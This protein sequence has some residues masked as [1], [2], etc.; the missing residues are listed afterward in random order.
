MSLSP[1]F[2]SLL[3]ILN[4][5][6]GKEKCKGPLTFQNDLQMLQRQIKWEFYLENCRNVLA[7]LPASSLSLAPSTSTVHLPKAHSSHSTAPL[8]NCKEFPTANK[9]KFELFRITSISLTTWSQPVFPTP[10]WLSFPLPLGRTRPCT[11]HLRPLSM[12]RTPLPFPSCVP[13][14]G[15][16]LP[17]TSISRNP[18]PLSTF[19]LNAMS[20]HPPR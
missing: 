13:Q 2:P 18:T 9:I 8:K 1:N 17:S 3:N 14:P 10:S 4:L 11:Q 7:G 16:P 5:I 12:P 19:S 6:E 20:V 15:K